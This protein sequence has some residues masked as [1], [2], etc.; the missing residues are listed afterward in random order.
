MLCGHSHG[1]LRPPNLSR[2]GGKSPRLEHIPPVSDPA[3]Y[4]PEQP[5]HGVIHPLVV[6]PATSDGY[7]LYLQ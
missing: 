1:V 3:G 7:R 6:C 5:P 2:A 4:G